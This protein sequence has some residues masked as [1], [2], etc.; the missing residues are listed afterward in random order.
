MSSN[1]EVSSQIY[2]INRS[3]A[4]PSVAMEQLSDELLYLILHYLD[5]LTL[6]GSISLVSKRFRRLSLENRLWYLFTCTSISSRGT[7]IDNEEPFFDHWTEIDWHNEWKWYSLAS[8]FL[9]IIR[10][11]TP[12]RT[13]W[14]DDGVT[15]LTFATHRSDVVALSDDGTLRRWR[16]SLSG[17][18]EISRTQ[19]LA[20]RETFR[21]HPNTFSPRSGIYPTTQLDYNDAIAAHDY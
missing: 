19:S 7:H 8:S 18:Q 12:L 2:I 15:V 20:G 11:N 10:Q 5:P 4:S 17:W 3:A 21:V 6:S 13:E 1:G 16:K 9:L 14:I